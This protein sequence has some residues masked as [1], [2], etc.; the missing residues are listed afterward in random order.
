MAFEVHHA[1]HPKFGG[2]ANAELSEVIARL[3]RAKVGHPLTL[4]C[5]LFLPSSLLKVPLFCM[6]TW[7]L[8]HGLHLQ[9][10]HCESAHAVTEHVRGNC[11]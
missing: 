4:G 7:P 10:T 2:N 3:A 11:T 8:R 9:W 5:M 6:T 1:L